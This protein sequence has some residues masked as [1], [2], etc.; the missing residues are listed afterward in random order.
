MYEIEVLIFRSQIFVKMLKYLDAIKDFNLCLE[1]D[2]KNKTALEKRGD[3]FL[4]L[5]IYDRALQDYTESD[6]ILPS[7]YFIYLNNKFR[8]LYSCK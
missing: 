4:L 2:P 5:E 1:L 3:I 8:K 6:K 7:K